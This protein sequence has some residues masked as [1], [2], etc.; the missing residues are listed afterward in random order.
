MARY[1]S[2]HTFEGCFKPNAL[3]F[4]Y[5]LSKRPEIYTICLFDTTG[6][7]HLDKDKVF[8]EDSIKSIIDPEINNWK[9]GS[10]ENRA[11]IIFGGF[12]KL[13][14][15]ESKDVNLGFL[16]LY[17][18]VDG[19]TVGDTAIGILFEPE[20][21]K[22]QIASV[23]DS[24]RINWLNFSSYARPEVKK[25]YDFGFGAVEDND[26][27]YW[28]GDK[29][30]LKADDS[31]HEAIFSKTQMVFAPEVSLIIIFGER[32]FYNIVL[33]SVEILKQFV[34]V[35]LISLVLIFFVLST[36]IL[37]K[38][39][40]VLRNQIALA[41]LAHAIKTPV[42]RIRLDTD[43]LLEEM[44][45]SPDEEREIITAIGRECGRM[46][47][48]VQSA[49]LSLEEGKRALNLDAGDLTRIVTNTAQAWQPQF[50]QA[51]IELKIDKTNE[52]FSGH[53]DAEMIAIMIDN[54]LDNALRH[55]GLNLENLGQNAVVTVTLKKS[56][57]KAVIII[58]DMGEGIPAVERKHIFKRFGR[59]KGDAASGVSGLGLGLSLVKEIAEAHGGKVRVADND[60][61]GA[62]FVVR[63]PIEVKGGR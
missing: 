39:K 55:T 59:V 10:L 29:T 19:T 62:R 3:R 21:F 17:P 16:M 11:K 45:A 34:F 14:I 25:R 37:Q 24:V 46:E 4:S 26:T 9:Q 30:K 52:P 56:D 23:I 13:A 18:S 32:R 33:S 8:L 20:W 50:V 41:H 42:A 31:Y 12:G 36:I 47:V 44:V 60:S 48:A 1:I 61:S 22:P 51:G 38:R 35:V 6:L 2:E 5:E 57:E 43:S 58:D 49:A 54:L 40:L 53:F 15:L 28:W 7:L 63:L 27:L